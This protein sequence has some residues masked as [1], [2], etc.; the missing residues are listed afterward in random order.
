MERPN[1]LR[2]VSDFSV[3]GWVG[4]SLG[5]GIRVEGDVGRHPTH[6]GHS[7]CP[8]LRHR[9]VRVFRLLRER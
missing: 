5:R 2:V 8:E 7:P 1:R 3:D 6:V 9:S 4:V